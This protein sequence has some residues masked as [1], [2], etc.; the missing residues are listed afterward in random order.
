[1]DRQ[2]LPPAQQLARHAVGV[3][4]VTVWLTAINLITTPYILKELG[5]ATYGVLTTVTLASSYLMN[6]EFGFG[7]ATVRFLAIA[8][9]RRDAGAE[10]AVADTSHTV[11]TVAAI[12]AGTTFALMAGV[13]VNHVF[14]VPVP[15]Q[16]Q[17]KIAFLLGALTLA[18]SFLTNSHSTILQARGWLGPLNSARACFG[19]LSAIASVSVI[20][21]GGRLVAVMAAQVLA[22]WLTALTLRSL[23][24]RALQR[25]PVLRL[26]GPMLRQMAAH[27]A[28]T[29]VAGVTYQVML[30]GPFLVLAT[31]VPSP[32]LPAFA[33]PA[34]I[35]QR[36][37]QLVTAASVSFFPF[38]SAAT[39]LND[40]DRFQQVFR[41][42]LRLQVLL[43]G[44]LAAYLVMFGRVLLAAWINDRFAEQAAAT[45]ALMAICL[46]FLALSAPAA[47]VA[48][49][50]GH[51][52]WVVGFTASAA[53][54]G[55]LLSWPLSEAYGGIG[56]AL[57]LLLSIATAALPFLLIVSVRVMRLAVVDLAVDLAWPLLAVALVT[58]TWCGLSLLSPT[59]PMA[60]VAATTVGAAY[61][62]A[63]FRWVL[64]PREK[65]TILGAARLR[66]A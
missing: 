52:G 31:Q 23:A 60:L 15:L 55:L 61:A 26:D 39:A 33:I 5:D 41:T 36:L 64:N 65:V 62:Y 58:A 48:R 11:F 38:A 37:I 29:F 56:A 47:D 44:A 53:T 32:Q 21:S 63:T 3:A 40:R 59:L 2:P 19:A 20:A 49:A 9:A 24:G 4:G 25:T 14:Q 17:A 22:T 42:H 18:A 7:F 54:A 35:L 8:S 10:R 13:L 34:S 16:G 45:L 12:V 57:A 50:A 6:L 28:L 27:G 1:M 43:V 51:P 46:F 66:R 30:T